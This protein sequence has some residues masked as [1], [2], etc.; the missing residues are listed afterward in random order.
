M[1]HAI[2]MCGTPTFE[3]D[4]GMV[5]LSCPHCR[6]AVAKLLGV[7]FGRILVMQTFDP[8]RVQVVRNRVQIVQDYEP[9]NR[10]GSRGGTELDPSVLLTALDRRR[11]E[12]IARKLRRG[13]A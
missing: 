8:R 11:E 12:V 6:E 1:A 5:K 4:D 7:R 9:G 10:D 13:Q 3:E 2:C